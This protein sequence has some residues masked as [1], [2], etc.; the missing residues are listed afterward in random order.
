MNLSS[1]I[2]LVSS[3]FIFFG[4]DEKKETMDDSVGGVSAPLSETPR[5]P[6]VAQE[7][8]VKRSP[9]Y[10][11]PS[12]VNF[13]NGYP[14]ELEID[15]TTKVP[16]NQQQYNAKFAEIVAMLKASK[17]VDAQQQAVQQPQVQQ[18]DRVMRGGV[19]EGMPIMDD[20]DAAR[21]Q[22]EWN[23]RQTEQGIAQDNVDS[24]RLDAEADY[25]RKKA[26][27]LSR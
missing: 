13:P 25:Q 2:V 4:C 5:A 3:M 9:C 11:Y 12:G 7:P 27:R 17:A 1:S 22:R 8:V 24:A 20:Q 19:L 15:C 18:N 6:L 10:R 23:A 14:A 26:E 16:V 21:L